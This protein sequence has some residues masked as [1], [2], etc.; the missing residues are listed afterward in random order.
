MGPLPCT[1][2]KQL[3]ANEPLVE[4]DGTRGVTVTPMPG[5]G[6]E[7]QDPLIGIILAQM[8]LCRD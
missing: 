8:K 7:A 1:M 5:R 2:S 4:P 6:R 3:Q